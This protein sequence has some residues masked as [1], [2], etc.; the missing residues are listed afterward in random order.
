MIQARNL[1]VDA[2][3]PV[4]SYY[5]TSDTSFDPNIYWGGTWVE[6]TAGRILVAQNTGTF[7]TVGA[8][9]GSESHK[10]KQTNN[11]SSQYANASGNQYTNGGT[12]ATGTVNTA[13]AT[14][15][16]PYIVVKRWHR[17]A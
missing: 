16:P 3:Y 2:I 11:Y 5:E 12:V 15:L 6:D 8:T 13:N 4:G 1:N 14:S 17:T 9:G 7:V 10:H